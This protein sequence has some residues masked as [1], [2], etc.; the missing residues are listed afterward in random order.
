MVRPGTTARNVLQADAG[1]NYINQTSTGAALVSPKMTKQKPPTRIRPPSL[2]T[3]LA[4]VQT[5]IFN[6]AAIDYYNILQHIDITSH[7]MHL[8][9]STT[10]HKMASTTAAIAPEL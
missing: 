6:P 4:L 5:R 2:L 3:T 8:I 1:T 10:S 9:S 7:N